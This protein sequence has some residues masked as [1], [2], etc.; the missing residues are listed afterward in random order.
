MAASPEELIAQLE[1]K[2]RFYEDLHEDVMTQRVLEKARRR[3]L[4][5]ITCG[6]VLVFAAGFFGF[7]ALKSFTEDLVHKKVDHLATWQVNHTLHA[8]AKKAVSGLM[9]HEQKVIDRTVAQQTVGLIKLGPIASH[10][11]GGVAQP[12]PEAPLR[13]PA[14]LD[15]TAQMQPV[16]D[17]GAEG[18]VDG[19][20]VASALEYQL[21]VHRHA[22]VRISPRYLYY[23]ARKAGGLD[24]NSDSGATL[25]N[26]MTAL[27]TKGAVTERAWPYVAGKYA[28]AP[29][30]GVAFAKHYSAEG[31]PLHGPDDIKAALQRSGP[32]VAGMT[33]Y[34]SFQSPRVTA[35]GVI[36]DPKPD[37]SVVG[38]HAICIV[39][40][41]DRKRLF[42]FENSWGPHWGDH[43]YGFVSYGYMDAHGAGAWALSV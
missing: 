36:P 38:G 27:A 40:Y 37:D 19:F 9:V 35:T 20:A 41:D 18:S 25:A 2:L 33:L 32:V 16:R 26:A 1:E 4:R 21:R 43:G 7:G 6:G 29:P 42:K 10:G 30:S 5:W 28:Q 15:Y 11:D 8:E 22:T 14:S 23:Y 13:A 17:S 39:G 12:A 31:R 24:V 34:E 3:M